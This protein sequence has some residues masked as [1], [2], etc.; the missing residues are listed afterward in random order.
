MFLI[1]PIYYIYMCVQRN[2]CIYRY[3][4]RERCKRSCN[5]IYIL[6]IAC[7]IIYSIYVCTMCQ[8]HNI[9]ISSI[10]DYKYLHVNLSRH[11]TFY[12]KFTAKHLTVITTGTAIINNYI[13]LILNISIAPVY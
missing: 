4:C 9:C 10:F 6:Y 13:A 2:I 5:F 1:V 8:Y 7:S 12:N 3:I 11:T